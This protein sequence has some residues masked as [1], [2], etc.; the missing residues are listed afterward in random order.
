MATLKEYF[1]VD[2]GSEVKCTDECSLQFKS[3]ATLNII[4][5]LHLDFESNATHISY[6]VPA[7][8]QPL[9]V[10][11]YLIDNHLALLKMLTRVEVATCLDYKESLP[12]STH[13]SSSLVFTNQI[14]L[15][16][17]SGLGDHEMGC[18]REYGAEKNLLIHIRDSEWAKRRATLEKPLAFICHDSRDKESIATKI[19][20]GLRRLLCPVWYDEY[21][22][23]VGQRLRESAE[24]GLMECKKCILVLTPRFLSNDGWT[25]AEFNSV[26]TRELVE[27]VN[28]ILP[29]WSEVSK[30][31]VYRYCPSLA[32]RVAVLWEEG[33]ENVLRKLYHVIMN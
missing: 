3:G 2:F 27:K 21:S 10:C 6:Y 16:L 30:D 33:E 25:K 20:S 24:K 18:I 14:S 19:A 7:T 15:Y 11:Q 28:I 8:D 9:E 23:Q 22:L 29:V 4:Q 12:E 26:F 5:R 31:E 32:D 17:D 1:D 13:H